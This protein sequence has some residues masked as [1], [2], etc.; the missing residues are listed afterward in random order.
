LTLSIALVEQITR[1]ISGSNARN[2]TNSAQALS[3]N[4][5]IAGYRPRSVIGIPRVVE[6]GQPMII[7]VWR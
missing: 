2:G 3:H 7:S 5:T 4:R 1:R 6:C